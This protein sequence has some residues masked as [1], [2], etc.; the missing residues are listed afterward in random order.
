M[1]APRHAPRAPRVPFAVLVLSLVVG[2][3]ALLLALNTA[4]AANELRRHDVAAKDAGV[5]A[6]LQVLRN[7]VAASAAP[8][9]LARAA[10]ALGMV[11]A[12]KPAFLVVGADGKV[13]VMGSPGVAQGAPVAVP[14]ATPKHKPKPKPRPTKTSTSARTSKSAS[15]SKSTSKS[16]SA[17]KSTPKPT[18]HTSP[19]PTSTPTPT[20]TL[21]GGGR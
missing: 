7:R 3:L 19:R 4:S 10:R 9:N 8:G 1:S 14:R 18:P 2:G 11:E 16:R 6:R 12:T 20:I 13:R 21:P 15:A 17:P 5:A